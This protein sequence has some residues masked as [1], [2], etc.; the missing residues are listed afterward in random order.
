[1]TRLR[2][3]VSCA[4]AC[5]LWVGVAAAFA[6]ALPEHWRSRA[7]EGGTLY[8]RADMP[9]G[10]RFE[11]WMSAAAAVGSAAGLDAWTAIEQRDRLRGLD[12]GDA[13]PK[14]EPAVADKGSVR[15]ACRAARAGLPSIGL[16]FFM[17]PVQDGRVRWGRVAVVGD[18]AVIERY[19]DE[20]K[21]VLGVALSSPSSPAAAPAREAARAPPLAPGRGVRPQDVE[22]VLF[23][24]DQVYRVSGLQYEETIYL[25]FKDGTAYAGLELAPQDLDVEASRRQ[26]PKRWM[27]WRK[28]GTQ[29]QV[30]R[31]D[32]G[33]WSS[34]KGWPAVAGGHDERLAGT[35]T[36]HA[37]GS[38]G[39]GMGGWSS[40]SSIVFKADGRF[41]RIG[42]SIMGTGVVQANNGFSSSTTSTHSG[43]GSSSTNTVSG[44]PV[45][46]GG[47]PTVAG[48][49]TRSRND[50]AA[51]TGRYRIDGWQIE[52]QR[53]DGSVERKLFLYNSSK[54]EVVNIGGVGYALPSKR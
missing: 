25:L 17:L 52:L 49:T 33:E 53:D 41:E 51:N 50:G 1:M 20:F 23:T 21:G 34:V 9:Q 19:Q 13:Q 27:Q 54:R 26:Q 5:A 37:Y 47:A 15:Q 39:A 45:E 6:Q 22:T 12:L 32:G 48:G 4:A 38:T 31:S 46:P 2:S 35:Y 36:H 7:H 43:K 29:W 8:E 42:S 24:W 16:Q 18:N 14:C 30:R 28:S 10:S 11:V 3:L 40:T 44:G